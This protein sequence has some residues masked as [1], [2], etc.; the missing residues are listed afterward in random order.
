MNFDFSDAQKDLKGDVRRLLQAHGGL[1]ATRE[2][3]D[4]PDVSYH[5]GL[6]Q[7]L[8]SQGW[9]G[10]AIPEAYGGVGLSRIELCAIAEELGRVL[11][12]VPFSSTV[13]LL[14]EAVLSFG[15]EAQKQRILPA[16]ARGDLI[17]CLAASEG[18]GPIRPETVSARVEGGRL[19]GVK[20]PVTDGDVADCALVLAREGSAVGLYLADLGQPGV[21]RET[22]ATLDKSRSH[23]RLSFDRTTVEPLGATGAGQELYDRLLDRAAVLFAFE[24]LGGADAC[25]EMATAYAKSRFAFGQPIGVNQA[26]KHKLADIYVNNEIARSNA[27]YGAWALNADAPELLQAAAAARIAASTAFDFAAKECLQTHGGMGFTWAVDCHLFLRRAR[28]LGV[29][30]GGIKVWKE[31]LMQALERSNS[32]A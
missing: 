9:L 5:G 14:A 23:A 16:I 22:L 29:Q 7:A 6:W 27:Y 30:L 8:A 31:R 21:S 32:A 10:A 2:V 11:A 20:L 18:P 17:G 13:F 26:I 4:T 25:L 28:L 3:M 19:S 15:T 12:P 1:T 24:Q